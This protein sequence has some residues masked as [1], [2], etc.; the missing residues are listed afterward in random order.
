[1]RCL[2]QNPGFT[3][4]VP[5]CRSRGL[6]RRDLAG[7]VVHLHTI[8]HVDDDAFASS[9][10]AERLTVNGI[11][12]D[13]LSYDGYLYVMFDFP[14]SFSSSPRPTPESPKQYYDAV[15]DARAAQAILLASTPHQ[16]SD[17]LPEFL[18]FRT[19][20]TASTHT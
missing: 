16:E 19:C 14:P 3:I 6:F 12:A 2:L 18:C 1:M 5:A 15:M 7:Y 4:W 11:V 13:F 17:I 20:R 8:L 9:Y 10:R